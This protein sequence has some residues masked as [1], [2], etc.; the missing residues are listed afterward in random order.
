ML[1]VPKRRKVGDYY[2]S[3]DDNMDNNSPGDD[4]DVN[5]KENQQNQKNEYLAGA[6]LLARR[7]LLTI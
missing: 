5:A 4:I 6:A 3:P 2:N 1:A 7:S